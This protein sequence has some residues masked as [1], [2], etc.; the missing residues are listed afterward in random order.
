MDHRK[1]TFLENDE[2]AQYFQ[3]LKQNFAELLELKCE[4]FY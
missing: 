1:K 3:L 2:N 4:N